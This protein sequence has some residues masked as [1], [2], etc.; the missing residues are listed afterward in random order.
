MSPPG[1]LSLFSAP[2][3]TQRPVWRGWVPSAGRTGCHREGHRAL[4][5]HRGAGVL[6]LPRPPQ[7]CVS[8]SHQPSVPFSFLSLWKT[9]SRGPRTWAFPAWSAAG[10][11]A[12]RPVESRHPPPPGPEHRDTR[13]PRFR[14]A[15]P[16]LHLLLQ[17][18]RKLPEGR[19]RSPPA[20]ARPGQGRCPGHQKPAVGP[21]PLS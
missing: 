14:S 20:P 8:S 12:T 1:D 15:S 21:R 2:T 19:H 3:R 10:N 16:W 11:T 6:S 13:C 9:G 5:P 4:C 17:R 7:P 18:K